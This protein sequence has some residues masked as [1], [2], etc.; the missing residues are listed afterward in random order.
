[1]CILSSYQR[2]AAESSGQE[3][4]VHEMV[5]GTW[6]MAY[7]TVSVR[8]FKLNMF[9]HIYS[10]LE[11]TGH[12][13]CQ[14]SFMQMVEF[15]QDGAW[16]THSSC[17][18][19]AVSI[20]RQVYSTRYV[21]QMGIIGYFPAT[22]VKET[23]QFAQDTVTIATTV[24]FRLFFFPKRNKCLMFEMLQ[25]W[26][27]DVF[28]LSGDGLLLRL[29]RGKLKNPTFFLDYAFKC[30]CLL[31]E[32]GHSFALVCKYFLFSFL[33]NRDFSQ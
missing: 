8:G 29:G 26:L 4:Y 33:G 12:L 1:M 24:S 18:G 16:R 5:P 27:I 9:L 21:D 25:C 17:R 10:M 11:H 23:H 15:T 20:F 13:C 32:P 28:L 22:M 6:D 14:S 31:T 7:T 30:C 2:R 19:R 3:A